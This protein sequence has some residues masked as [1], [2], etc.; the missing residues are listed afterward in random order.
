MENEIHDANAWM[1]MPKMLEGKRLLISLT[2]DP[3]RV[4][5]VRWDKTSPNGKYAYLM[6]P[7][8]KEPLVLY[9]EKF[10]IRDVL[11]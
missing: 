11:E 1:S 3:E 6:E 4:F 9:V 5:E 2:D 8:K 7:L 10:N